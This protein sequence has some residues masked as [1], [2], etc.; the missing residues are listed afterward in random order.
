M[1]VSINIQGDEIIMKQEINQ[2]KVLLSKVVVL[3]PSLEPDEMM[4]RYVNQL[5][6]VGFEKIVLVNDGSDSSY[7]SLFAEV[8]DKVSV[9]K[10]AVNQGKGRALKTG[11][12]YILNTY[13]EEEIAGVVTADAD[14]QHSVE[15]TVKVSL[16]LVEEG[17]FVLGTR[18]FNEPQVPFKSRN[19]NKITTQVFKLLY[20]KLIND[21]QTGLRGIPYSYIKDCLKLP[22]ERFEY[23]IHMLIDAIQKKLQISEVLIQTI[24]YDSNRATHFSAVKDS[25]RIYKVIFTNFLQFSISG[26]LSF[27]IDI[28]IFSIL[29]KCILVNLDVTISVL[30]GTVVA[31]VISSICNYSMNRQIF[32]NE[33]AVK[34]SIIRYYT[35]CVAQL[36]V[37]WGLV[38]CVFNQVQW[39]TTVIKII[40]DMVLFFISYQIQKNWVFRGGKEC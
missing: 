19:G 5:H 32:R 39:D 13:S 27:L 4:V 40:V 11:F 34:H 16:R 25:I 6:E 9:L 35:L 22:G 30:I 28:I 2:T 1:K 14:G 36:L 20:G 29:T 38:V 24:Y 12:H 37:S 10:H 3:I 7:D 8:A 31:R 26:I 15:D 21:T 23:E 18:N 17:S 33:G